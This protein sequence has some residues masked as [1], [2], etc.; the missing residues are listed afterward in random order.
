QPGL[1]T[2]LAALLEERDP[3]SREAAIDINL[4]I[5]ALRRHRAYA[6][7]SKRFDNLEKIARSYRKL[8]STAEENGA[9]DA[10]ATGLLLTYAYPERIAKAR[11]DGRGTFQLANGKRAVVPSGDDLA[12]AVWL[13]IASLDARDG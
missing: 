9:V 4:R 10:H 12:H 5:E 11:D 1:A 3:L 13:A 8:L 6:K 7:Q 2:D